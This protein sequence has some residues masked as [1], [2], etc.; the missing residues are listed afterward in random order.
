MILFCISICNTRMKNFKPGVLV[1]FRILYSVIDD[2]G[3]LVNYLKDIRKEV[4]QD[5][6]PEWISVHLD[7]VIIIDNDELC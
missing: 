4:L 6:L 2:F 5:R 1:V 7:M 3:Y